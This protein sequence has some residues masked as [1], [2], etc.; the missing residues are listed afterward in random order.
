MVNTLR[1]YHFSKALKS[2]VRDR[3]N[4]YN[5]QGRLTI[6]QAPGNNYGNNDSLIVRA[7][8]EQLSNGRN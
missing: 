4:S 1:K 2:L 5:Q 8:P 3:K 6:L 7:I